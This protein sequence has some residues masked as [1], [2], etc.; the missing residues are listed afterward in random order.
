[1][2]DHGPHHGCHFRLITHRR[3]RTDQK[4]TIKFELGLDSLSQG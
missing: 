1:M 3:D 4:V 2:T